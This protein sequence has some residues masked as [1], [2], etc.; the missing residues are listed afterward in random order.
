MFNDVSKVE[1][2]FRTH[3]FGRAAHCFSI[4]F[5]AI[6][7]AISNS[8]F[9]DKMTISKFLIKENN[10]LD[11]IRIV[12]ASMVIVGHSYIL[13][14]DNGQV[15]VV[16]LL[17]GFTYSGALAVKI[18]FFI[19][20]MLVTDS[21]LRKKSF[22]SFIISR[23][24]RMM[25]GLLAVLLVSSF[26]VGPLLSSLPIATYFRSLQTYKYIASNLLF[27]SNYELP[28]VFLHNRLPKIV[29]GS[30]WSLRLE[31]RCYVFL[32][33]VF[34]LLHRLR[35]TRIGFNIVI[36]IIFADA[37][38]GWQ[39]IGRGTNT[40]HSLLPMTFALGALFAVNKDQIALDF[41]FFAALVVLAGL[42]WFTPTKEIVFIVA[43]SYGVLMLCKSKLIKRIKIG[44]DISYGI[45][46]WGFL[47]QQVV[48]QLMGPQHVYRYMAI[49]II[50]SA[51]LGYL[52]FVFI[53][54]YFMGIGRQLDKKWTAFVASRSGEKVM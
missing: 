17:T 18:F 1:N 10:N 45:Y 37:L 9:S 33:G 14:T 5:A 26:I 8:M 6:L 44:H 41:R 34:L 52:S 15:D 54:Q 3:N 36:A 38:F 13:S 32:L 39:V 50:I 49:C 35:I 25:P 43:T 48:Y 28:G 42:C 7:I 46:L 21:L 20:G 31:V 11:F 12:C 51:M 2:I 16:K 30:L 19:S 4:I 23:A 40:E 29:N 53:E 27:F 47:V 24:S 22:G